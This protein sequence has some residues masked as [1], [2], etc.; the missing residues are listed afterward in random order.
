MII[1]DRK[2]R[3]LPPVYNTARPFEQ[4]I[5]SIEQPTQAEGDGGDESFG[6]AADS[7]SIERP[8]Q[9]E[10]DDGESIE[11]HIGSE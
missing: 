8:I 6:E 3:Y 1:I 5:P 2:R 9:T 7:V 4:P 11:R 10:S